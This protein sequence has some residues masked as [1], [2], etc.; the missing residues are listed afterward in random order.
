MFQLKVGRQPPDDDET[1]SLDLLEAFVEGLDQAFPY[2][3]WEQ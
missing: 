3:T 2:V 1:G